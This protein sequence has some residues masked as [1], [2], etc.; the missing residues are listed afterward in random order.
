MLLD[1]LRFVLFATA[2]LLFPDGKWQSRWTQ[3]V[4]IASGFVFSLGSLEALGIVQSRLFLPLAILCVLA[5]I[6]ALVQRFRETA[7]ETQ[8]QQLKWVSLGLVTGGVAPV[9]EVM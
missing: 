9:A 5:A 1:R 8:R 2:L 7:D 6:G 3:A 4:A